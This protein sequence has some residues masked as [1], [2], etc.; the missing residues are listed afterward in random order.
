MDQFVGQILAVGFNF[1]PV[2]WLLCDGTQVPISQYDV[3]YNLLGTTFGGNGTTTF[4]LPDLRGRSPLG[5]QA[6]APAYVL[7]QAA[8]AES[9]TLTSVQNPIHTHILNASTIA[10][11]TPVPGPSVVLGPSP[12]AL[13]IS[14]YDVA[15][16][17]TT[18]AANTEG[19]AGSSLPHEN[20]QP[21]NTVNYII[22]YTGVYP[23]SS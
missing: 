1:A 20:R 10:A 11:T 16:G 5:I 3:L 9:V 7:G 21:F 23:T 13:P 12:S 22:A 6:A 4:G 17:N 8:G 15:P 18:L 2:G 19:P 14:V